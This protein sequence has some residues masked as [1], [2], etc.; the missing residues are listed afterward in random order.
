MVEER[1]KN[2][3]NDV[4]FLEAPIKILASIECYNL[5]PN[6]FESLIHGFLHAQRLKIT[7][8]GKSGKSYSPR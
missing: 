4:A 7:L 8:T 2:A 6:K 3:V 5:N 1:I